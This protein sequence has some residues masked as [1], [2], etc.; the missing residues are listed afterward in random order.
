MYIR[1]YSYVHTC[2]FLCTY[3]CILM[4]IRVYS[5]VYTCVFLCIFIFLVG[6]GYSDI[7]NR[8]PCTPETVM[9]I[10]SIS[11]PIS[12]TVIAKLLE[13][14]KIDLDL[15]I[16]NY[17]KTWP[18]KMVDGKKVGFWHFVWHFI[19]FTVKFKY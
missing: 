10:A 9:R 3:V 7:E 15:P 4:Y 18:S 14:K 5:C 2:V 8:T 12:M 17:V 6:F 19:G 11:K 13:D 1:V 16:E